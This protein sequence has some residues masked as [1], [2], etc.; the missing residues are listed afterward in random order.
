MKQFFSTLF[1][2][3][4]FFLIIPGVLIVGGIVLLLMFIFGVSVWDRVQSGSDTIA[5]YDCG[6]AK[7]DLVFSTKVTIEDNSEWYNYF[8]RSNGVEIKLNRLSYVVRPGVLANEIDPLPVHTKFNVKVFEL[9]KDLNPDVL[10]MFVMTPISNEQFAKITDCLESNLAKINHD[11][12]STLPTA[13]ARGQLYANAE[14]SIPSKLGGIALVDQNTLYNSVTTTLS[15][16]GVFT[17]SEGTLFKIYI[18]PNGLVTNVKNQYLGDAFI[19]GEGLQKYA[20]WTNQKGE[21]FSQV[22]SELQT[23]L[24]VD[25]TQI[26]H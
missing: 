2:I 8:Y 21:T 15:R 18:R 23:A 11:L 3:F 7:I 6:D 4:G 12:E 25:T 17:E 26:T 9:P 24:G 1:K 16:R 20:N 14:G 22:F 13:A 5:S 10:N 19:G